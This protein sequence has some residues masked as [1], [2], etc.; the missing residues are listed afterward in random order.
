VTGGLDP[1][2]FRSALKPWKTVIVS[3]GLCLDPFSFR[4]ALKHPRLRI[5][6]PINMFQRAAAKCKRHPKGAASRSGRIVA[7]RSCTVMIG[8][9]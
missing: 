8:G 7:Q 9:V 5:A 6:F 1:F 2:S 4:S 3:E